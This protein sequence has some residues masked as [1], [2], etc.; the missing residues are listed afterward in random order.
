MITQVSKGEL[1]KNRNLMWTK[2]GKACLILIFS[3]NTNCESMAHRSFR[4]EEYSARGDRKVT[5]G[6][7]CCMGMSHRSQTRVLQHTHYLA[8]TWDFW[9][10]GDAKRFPL[11]PLFFHAF[12]FPLSTDRML[13]WMAVATPS[14]MVSGG[15]PSTTL[16]RARL[17]QRPWL[18]QT[19]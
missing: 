6:I 15:S 7:T 4:A 19:V 9:L 14:L 8:S 13:V 16:N 12:L 3:T 2:R 10:I 18:L 11:L 17:L 1:N 5:T